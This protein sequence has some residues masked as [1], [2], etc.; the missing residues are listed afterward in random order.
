[1][2]IRSLETP[3]TEALQRLGDDIVMLST[4]I[5]VAT[6]RL[7]EMLREFDARGG[8]GNGFLS[9]A[10][11]LAWAAHLDLGT[12]RERVRVARALGKLP[13]VAQAFARGELSYA[14]IRH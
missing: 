6:A 10:H 9:C 13:L 11:W 4:H 5:D 1:M 8:W 7:L 3:E 2:E 14:K 12:A